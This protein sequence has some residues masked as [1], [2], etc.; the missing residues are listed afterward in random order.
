MVVDGIIHVNSKSSTVDFTHDIFF[1]WSLL[2]VLLEE[3]EEWLSKIESFGQPP[4]IARVVELLA[5]REFIDNEWSKHLSNPKFKELR[6]QWLRAWV[7]GPI[8]HPKFIESNTEYTTA[9]IKNDFHLVDSLLIWFQAEKTRANPLLLKQKNQIEEAI[10]FA[11]PS[12]I[13]LWQKLL[14]Y[15]FNLIPRTPH[16]LYPKIL[17]IFEVW[18]YVGIHIPTNRVSKTLLEISLNWL[19]EISKPEILDDWKQITNFRDFKLELIKL[20]LISTLSEPSYTEKYLN[21]LLSHG[22]VA[23]TYL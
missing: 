4:F 12:D 11:W 16:R 23:Q 3:Q 1:E 8:Q 6:S 5:Q 19:I 18:Q 21:F 13:L 14:D 20:I 7:I 2:Y 22:F 9:L 10:H 17:K 15:I